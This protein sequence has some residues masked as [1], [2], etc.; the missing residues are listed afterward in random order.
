MELIL[1]IEGNTATLKIVGM[2]ITENAY[3]IGEKLDEVLKSDALEF[4]LDFSA[5]R[6]ICS[7]GIGRLIVFI[8][9]YEQKGGKM[10]VIK[11][12]PNVYELFKTIKFDSLMPINQ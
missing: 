1:T 4:H 6:L 8:K 5:C 12:S 10:D 2:I 3:Q 7:K 9:D 11:C